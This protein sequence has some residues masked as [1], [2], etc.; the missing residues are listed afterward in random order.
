MEVAG[1]LCT[2]TRGPLQ[3]CALDAA[4]PFD[5]ESRATS[6][7]KESKQLTIGIVGFGTFGQFLAKRLVQH[8][9]K[10]LATSRTNY[11]HEAAGLG[12]SFFRDPDDFCEEHPDVV[13]LA[14]AILALEKV[15]GSLPL[16]RL[17]RSTLIVDVLSVKQFPKQLLLSMLPPEMDVLCTHPMFGPDSGKGSWGGLNLMYDK[18]R[19]GSAGR[20]QARVDSFLQFFAEQGCRMVEMSC[21]EHDRLAAGTQFITHSVGRVLG[22]MGLE[23]TSIDTKGFE[24]LLRLVDNTNNDSFDLYYGLFMYNQNATEELARLEAAFDS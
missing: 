4:M 12:V 24:A 13:I 2:R 9:H 20:R 6:K 14:C 23:S 10:V 18:V 3:T 1:G 19:I 15:I 5:Y 11:Q 22:E 8:G 17:R 21:E 16:Q 7:I